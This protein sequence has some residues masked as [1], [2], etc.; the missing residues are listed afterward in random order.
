MST[1]QVMLFSKWAEVIRRHTRL[2]D[3]CRVDVE[4]LID[5][6]EIGESKYLYGKRQQEVRIYWRFVGHIPA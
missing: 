2:E 3:I 6:I 5:H 4:E 1:V